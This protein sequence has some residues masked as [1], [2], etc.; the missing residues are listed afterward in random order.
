MTSDDAGTRRKAANDE[1]R[2]VRPAERVHEAP[3]ADP[4][5]VRERARRA[6]QKLRRTPGE[7]RPGK[8]VGPAQGGAA[9]SGERESPEVKRPSGPKKSAPADNPY[10]T[11]IPG[12]TQH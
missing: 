2:E 10:T 5:A 6:G 1:K 12:E 9:D 4:A 3:A 11:D 8:R 7:I